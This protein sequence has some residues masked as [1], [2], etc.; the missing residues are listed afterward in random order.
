[1]QNSGLAASLAVMHFNPLAAVP[2]AIFS[3]WHNV[4]GSLLANYFVRKDTRKD[5][6]IMKAHSAA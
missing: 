4:S 3:L 1:M 5:D 2:G 6:G